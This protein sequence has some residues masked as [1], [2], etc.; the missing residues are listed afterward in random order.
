MSH[1]HSHSHTHHS[2]NNQNVLLLTFCL[3][4]GFMLIE[5]IGGLWTNSLALLSDAGHML[6]DAAAL[7]LSYI[8]IKVAK[9]E[10]TNKKTFGFKRFEILAAA[11]NGVT[12]I[13]IA[14]L[15]M[16][17]S[18][19]RFISPPEVAS[20]GMLTIATIGFLVN[21]VAAVILM[22][23]DK[24]ENLNVKSAFLHVIGDLLGSVGAIIA[25]L[26]IYFFGWG[27]ADPIASLIVA[28]LIINSGY[29]VTKEAFH[30]LMEGAP[31]GIQIEQI[32]ASIKTLNKVDDVHDIHLWT[33]TS[34]FPAFS[35]HIVLNDDGHH[36]TVLKE[37]KE[38]LSHQF[39]INHSTI[40]VEG[41][42][43]G[44]PNL[45]DVCN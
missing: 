15:I 1:H 26:L 13:V 32:K 5:F 6:S 17:E 45:E 41:R 38:L 29:R 14:I 33:I 25:G 37:T 34:G 12:L 39:G 8:A 35:C 10:S 16:I 18:V 4:F 42:S 43:S 22:K 27:I 31:D 21:I 3:I 20:L 23:G 24:D 2:S 44:C 28:I 36:D 11:I 30:V 9:R 40:Q 19:K 7:G